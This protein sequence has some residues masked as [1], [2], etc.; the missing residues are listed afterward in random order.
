M[1][2]VFT[3]RD[4]IATFRDGK[5]TGSKE[6]YQITFSD[7]DFELSRLQEYVTI[8]SRG[9]VDH[10]RRMNSMSAKGSL[11]WRYSDKDIAEFVRLFLT[12]KST[13]T[14]TEEYCLAPNDYN[15]AFWTKNGIILPVGNDGIAPDG[16]SIAQR[17]E[18]VGGG[19]G[20]MTAQVTIEPELNEFVFFD[21][22]CKAQ[23]AH[24]SACEAHLTATGAP[25]PPFYRQWFPVKTYWQK[26]T[27]GFQCQAVVKAP[28]TFTCRIDTSNVDPGFSLDVWG[29]TIRREVAAT[30]TWDLTFDFYKDAVL[31][32]RIYLEHVAYEGLNFDEDQDGSIWFLDIVSRK[33]T[34]FEILV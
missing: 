16:F 25:N 7:A 31:E 13:S 3:G 6:E 12:G 18:P 9:V 14:E 24:E 8:V 10:F 17:L 4:V 5:R 28:E 34:P 23:V 29:V 27:G 22:W 1:A 20:W 30:K 15:D 21:F 2:F 11:S 33:E 32:R 26:I 19:I